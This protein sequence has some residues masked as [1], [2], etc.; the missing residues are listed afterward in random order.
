MLSSSLLGV[1][2]EVDFGVEDLGN[3]SSAHFVVVEAPE[4]REV[5]G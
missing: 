2:E 5:E 1:N 4:L 3:G